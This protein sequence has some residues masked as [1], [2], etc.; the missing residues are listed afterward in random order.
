MLISI[1]Q[2]LNISLDELMDNRQTVQPEEKPV[3]AASE[4]IFISKHDGSKG[5]N[6]LSVEYSKILA[7]AR[8]EPEYLL[9]AVEKVGLLGEHREI[10]GWYEDEPTVKKE[11]DDI[12]RAIDAGERRYSLQY[13]TQ[14]R[15]TVFGTAARKQKKEK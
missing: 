1:A 14:V 10:L 9:S 12:L 4:T 11:M 8:N 6:C 13:Y 7:P 3:P 15:F 5:V 2:K